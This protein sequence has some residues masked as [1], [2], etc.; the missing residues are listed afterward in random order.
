[1]ETLDREMLVSQGIAK[2]TQ[3]RGIAVVSVGRCL[4][5]CRVEI[6]D[7]AGCALPERHVGRIW[8]QSDCMFDGYRGQPELSGRILREGW[9]DSGDRGY[10]AGE[11]V[12]FVSREKDLVVIG[13][14][15][16]APHDIEQ[17]LFEVPGVRP[18]CAV[19]FGVLNEARGT[20]DLAVVAETREAVPEA[21][22]G[23]EAAIRH[24]VMATLGLQIRYV[25]LVGPGEI[26]KT[27]SGKL[28]RRATRLR[29]QDHWGGSP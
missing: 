7:G 21:R 6:R 27:T 16:H 25:V 2:P 29:Y 23:L 1:M 20:E 24:R 17:Q 13:G 4:P 26:E 28:A 5:R 3:D 15:K 8:I 9:L 14:E 19:A 12:F 22:A 18:G 10:L 11:E